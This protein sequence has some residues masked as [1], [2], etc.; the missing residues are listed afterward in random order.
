[1]EFDSSSDEEVSNAA[2]DL[3]SSTTKSSQNKEM[4]HPLIM[5]IASKNFD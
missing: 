1:M 4:K 2:F 5:E 3:Q